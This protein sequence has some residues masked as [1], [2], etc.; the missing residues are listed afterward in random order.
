MLGSILCLIAFIEW[1]IPMNNH[2]CHII[3]IFLLI[4]YIFSILLTCHYTHIVLL[5]IITTA[6]LQIYYIIGHDLMTIL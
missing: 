4:M 6:L 1:C 5:L 2:P 3:S